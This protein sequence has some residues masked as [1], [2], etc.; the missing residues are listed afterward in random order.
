MTLKNNNIQLY[1]RSIALPVKLLNIS[2]IKLT[3]K[4]GLENNLIG[5]KFLPV[6]VLFVFFGWPVGGYSKTR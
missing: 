2:T 6:T 5:N 3:I 4:F 1:Y